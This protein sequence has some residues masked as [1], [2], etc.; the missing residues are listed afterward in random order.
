M[1]SLA[2]WRTSA[3]LS[4]WARLVWK[5]GHQGDLF[6]TPTQNSLER[7]RSECATIV[8]GNTE[9]CFT[10]MYIYC[11]C[12]FGKSVT[13]L[14]RCRIYLLVVV[15]LLVVQSLQLFSRFFSLLYQT[16]VCISRVWKQLE[17]PSGNKP[18]NF[19]SICVCPNHCSR[20]IVKPLWQRWELLY[21]FQLILYMRWLHLRDYGR[22]NN[23]TPVVSSFHR[24]MPNGDYARFLP[25]WTFKKVKFFHFFHIENFQIG[26]NSI[27]PIYGMS[28]CSRCTYV[29]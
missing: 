22:V 12:C 13:S 26:N 23:S 2:T 19:T 6:T 14:L 11:C 7:R 27:L 10:C 3:Q 9:W 17:I 4:F 18:A 5:W 1:D 28:Q 20:L 24:S 29:T 21:V 25:T 16:L 15:R 8:A